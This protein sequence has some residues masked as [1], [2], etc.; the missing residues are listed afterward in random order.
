[1]D[2]KETWEETVRQM[3]ESPEFQ[4]AGVMYA[5]GEIDRLRAE[6]ERLKHSVKIMASNPE[7][8]HEDALPEDMPEADYDAWYQLSILDCGVRVGPIYPPNAPDNRGA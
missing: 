8:M 2:A 4:D 3:R 7:V 6:N 1:M 5:Q